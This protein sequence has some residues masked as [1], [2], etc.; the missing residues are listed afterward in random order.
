MEILNSERLGRNIVQRARE[1]D[2]ICHISAIQGDGGA[3]QKIANYGI[4]DFQHALGS[5]IAGAYDWGFHK[6]CLDFDVDTHLAGSSGHD[7]HGG[8]VAVGVEV[9]ALQLGDF[10]E[11]RLGQLANFFLVGNLGTGSQAE[12][13]LNEGAC[14]RLLG[15]EGEGL[16]L[17]NGDHHWENIAG[18]LLGR[19]VEFLTEG[20]D[21]HTGLTEGRTDWRSWI[22]LSRRDLQL[23][24]FD[25]FFCHGSRIL[26]FRINDFRL[27]LNQGGSVRKLFGC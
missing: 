7:A 14:W 20:H 1:F 8:F 15:D 5:Q 16:V 19:S 23:D 4:L 25:D 6:G 17:V 12:S 2:I 22:R 26:D 11:L 24:D 21:V 9:R 10:G 13:L 27:R 3:S 18:R